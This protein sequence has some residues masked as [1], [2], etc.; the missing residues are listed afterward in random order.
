GGAARALLQAFGEARLPGDLDHLAQQAPDAPQLRLVAVSFAH[1]LRLPLVRRAGGASG[2]FP[3]AAATSPWLR[4]AT[5]TPRC[6]GQATLRSSAA[7]A[8]PGTP[9]AAR[10][11]RTARC[12]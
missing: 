7:A 11:A 1:L 8:P 4:G 10:R 6:G 12:R 2:A 3:G 5:G 9:A